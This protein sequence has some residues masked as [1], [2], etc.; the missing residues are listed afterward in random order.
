MNCRPP[1]ETRLAAPSKVCQEINEFAKPGIDF[2]C[3]ANYRCGGNDR[4][5]V[6]LTTDSPPLFHDFPA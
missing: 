1:G 5:S 3:M 2:Q 6:D 4:E